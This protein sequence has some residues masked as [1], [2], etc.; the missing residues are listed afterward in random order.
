MGNDID[1]DKYKPLNDRNDINDEP[2]TSKQTSI[3]PDNVVV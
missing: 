3:N 1:G 2:K